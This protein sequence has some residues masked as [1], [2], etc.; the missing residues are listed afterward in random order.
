MRHDQP[1][2]THGDPHGSPVEFEVGLR[3]RAHREDI[4]GPEL[5]ARVVDERFVRAA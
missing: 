1:A 3:A 4:A 2:A 5:D